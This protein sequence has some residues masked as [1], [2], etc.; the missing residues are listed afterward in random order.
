MPKLSVIV[1]TYN[2][3]TWL[4]KVLIG[5]QQQAVK[6]FE[7]IV[8]DDG[9][10]WKT[11]KLLETMRSQSFFK[12]KHAWHEDD[13]F[14]KTK[15]LNKAVG[16]IESDYV[17]FTDGDCI[18]RK[19][20]LTKHIE[21]RAEN[22][23]LSGGYYKMPMSLSN[24][25]IED[26]II[27]QKCFNLDWLLS[28]GLPKS[29]KN[30]KLTAHGWQE[31]MLNMLTPTKA[32]WNGS[33]AS[34]WTKDLLAVNG[35]DERMKYGGEDREFGERLENLGIKG[36]QIRYSAICVH[37]DH[38]RGYVDQNCIRFNNGIRTETVKSKLTWTNHGIIGKNS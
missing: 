17:I 16:L 14:Q 4:E 31:K 18:P 36:K 33:N 22:R 37:L 9:S 25:I 27:N 28:N 30:L 2:S 13:G 15:I 35:F 1:S 38:G 11:Q 34:C 5:Y 6:D 32:T 26:D 24:T 12:I 3:P 29:Y 8:A 7:L 10:D 21:M 20:F 23:F 19:D